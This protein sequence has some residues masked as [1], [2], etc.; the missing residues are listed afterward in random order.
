MPETARNKESQIP[1][2]PPRGFR[3]A[4]SMRYAEQWSHMRS[5]VERRDTRTSLASLFANMWIYI[6][7]EFMRNRTS[8]VFANPGR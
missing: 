8:S 4:E 7:I 2:L 6:T 5:D 1:P 3:N